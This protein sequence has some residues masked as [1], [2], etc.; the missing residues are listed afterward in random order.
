VTPDVLLVEADIVA[1]SP[2]ADYLRQCGFRVIEAANGDEAKLAL[3]APDLN[4]HAVLVDMQ[5]EG[6]GFAL[7]QWIRA[8]KLDVQVLLAGSTEKTIEQAASLCNEGPALVKPYEHHLV[9]ERI[10][11]AMARRERRL[12]GGSGEA[13]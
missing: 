7:W 13:E 11:Q 8:E 6:G 5:T 1:R 3:K 9:R 12:R 10:R 2:L 4:I